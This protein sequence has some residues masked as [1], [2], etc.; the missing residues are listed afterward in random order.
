MI[1]AGLAGKSFLILPEESPRKVGIVQEG[2]D[3][4]A[5]SNCCIAGI[6]FR[7]SGWYCNAC[8]K[9]LS[10]LPDQWGLT[11]VHSMQHVYNSEVSRARSVAIVHKW[12]N[13][14]TGFNV[15]TLQVD[16][17]P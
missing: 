3:L 9:D 5:V 4:I 10:G 17:R 1:G 8:K 13:T 12:I 16:V 6:A 2:I 7:S 11:S 15:D 14:W